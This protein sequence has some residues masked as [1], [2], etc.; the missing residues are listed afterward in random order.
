VIQNV[1]TSTPYTIKKKTSQVNIDTMENL[2]RAEIGRW[3][4]MVQKLGLSS[5]KSAM[6]QGG[7]WSTPLEDWS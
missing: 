6:F 7:T 5:E 2:V 1:R 4:S 3:T